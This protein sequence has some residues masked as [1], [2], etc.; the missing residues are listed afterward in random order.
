MSYYDEQVSAD[1]VLKYLIKAKKDKHAQRLMR[2]MEELKYL[3]GKL[4][5]FYEEQ[6]VKL[7]EPRP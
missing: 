6:S 5:R 4:E 7:E 2:M 3:Q 1:D